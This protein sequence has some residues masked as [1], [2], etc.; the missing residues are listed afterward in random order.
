MFSS[1]CKVRVRKLLWLP[2]D[3]LCFARGLLNPHRHPSIDISGNALAPEVKRAARE[4][5]TFLKERKSTVRGE[6]QAI[7]RVQHSIY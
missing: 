4:C 5:K 6:G 2:R 1:D 7:A 3:N